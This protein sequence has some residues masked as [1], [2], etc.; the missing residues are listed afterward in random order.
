MEG[1]I[2]ILILILAII[3][4][5]Y[6]GYIKVSK[7]IK[8]VSRELLG[9][10]DF[11]KGLKQVEVE[12]KNTPLSVS[13]GTKLYLPKILNDFPEY[14]QSTMEEKIK[15]FM[16]LYFKCL[17]NME[18]SH[19]SEIGVTDSV[20]EEVSSK[21]LD[22]LD[23]KS[24]R[25]KYDDIV[26]HAVSIV[27]YTKSKEFATVKYQISLGYLGNK[28]K[29]QSKYEVDVSYLFEDLDSKSFSLRCNHCGG[30]LKE[31]SSI[32]EYCGTIVVR[33]IT[34]VWLI[35]NFKLINQIG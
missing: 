33:N 11:I 2:V 16:L 8:S 20:K 19:L 25:Q 13:G 3:I 14:H 4:A 32:C 22:L 28:G 30:D 10:E 35:S 9:T 18:V 27:R 7:K 17:E 31:T 15:Q 1:L 6:I 23:N 12:N 24:P 26:I 21:I 29:V 5:V 34:K